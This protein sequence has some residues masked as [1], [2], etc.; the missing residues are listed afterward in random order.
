MPSRKPEV[1]RVSGTEVI[2]KEGGEKGEE[3][4]ND[5]TMSERDRE[6]ETPGRC[7]QEDQ[8]EATRGRRGGREQDAN[9]AEKGQWC[10][11]M[12]PGQ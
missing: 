1:P 3:H 5:Q 2:G 10:R 12:K 7:G 11:E 4:S 9:G 8:K 6:R